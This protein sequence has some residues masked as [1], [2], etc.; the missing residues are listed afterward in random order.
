MQTESAK[1]SKRSKWNL[2]LPE[3]QLPLVIYEIKPFHLL[4]VAVQYKGATR[5]DPDN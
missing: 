4:T 2:L 1:V 5:A 3:V